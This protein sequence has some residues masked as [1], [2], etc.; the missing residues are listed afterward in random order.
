MNILFSFFRKRKNIFPILLVWC[1][2]S[3]KTKTTSGSASKPTDEQVYAFAQ[4]KYPEISQSEFQEGKSI[5]NNQCKSCHGIKHIQSRSEQEWQQILSEMAP[6]AKLN[7]S[8]KNNLTRYL[9]GFREAL[10][11]FR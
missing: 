2:C 4:S 1:F 5:L 7:A 10:L 3:C 8:Q 11:M 9:F 6:K